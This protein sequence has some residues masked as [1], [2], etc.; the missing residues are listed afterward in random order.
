M[1]LKQEGVGHP[2][3]VRRAAWDG[4]LEAVLDEYLNLLFGLGSRE[5]I[6][7]K[8]EARAAQTMTRALNLRASTLSVQELPDTSRH[9]RMR[10]HAALPLGIHD[11]EERSGENLFRSDYLRH[12]FNSP[13]RPHV[14]VTT[15]IG[16]EGLDFHRYCQHI[17][18]WDLP[19]NP[20]DL[21]QR[22]GRIRRYGGLNVRRAL[23]EARSAP[24]ATVEPGRSPW[25]AL[26]S[27]LEERDEGLSP[28]WNLPG[29]R[30]RRTVYV[31]PFSRVRREL[32]ELLSDL[33]LYRLTLGQADQERLLEALR[34]RVEQ[35][36]SSALEWFHAARFNLAPGFSVPL[37]ARAQDGGTS[38]AG[39]S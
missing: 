8:E 13:F 10:C 2:A 15:S 3:N 9:F 5:A 20:V 39:G 19:T 33:A 24:E 31:A 14:L 28:W 26:T 36:D 27:N 4:N 30:T 34:R 25:R 18:H 35:E 37:S 29:A 1:T 38:S 17:V 32:D 7:A 12:A 11:R 16:Q 23:V 21:E 22:D 6:A